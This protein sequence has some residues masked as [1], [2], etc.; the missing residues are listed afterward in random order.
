M[1]LKA[2]RESLD[3]ATTPLKLSKKSIK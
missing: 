3:A 1:Q 2:Q